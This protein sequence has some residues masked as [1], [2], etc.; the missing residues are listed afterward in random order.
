MFHVNDQQ[1]KSGNFGMSYSF[2]ICLVVGT[3]QRC[4]FPDLTGCQAVSCLAL[5]QHSG[6]VRSSFLEAFFWAKVKACVLEGP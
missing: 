1:E 5:A 6:R 3:E 4:D 2:S